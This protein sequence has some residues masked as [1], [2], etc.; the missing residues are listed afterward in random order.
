M[1]LEYEDKGLLQSL[2]SIHC[3]LFAY[4]S[5]LLLQ[6]MSWNI[7]DLFEQRTIRISSQL[8]ERTT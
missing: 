3:S 5:L 8:R 1:P 6:L 4:Y 7:G 2:R